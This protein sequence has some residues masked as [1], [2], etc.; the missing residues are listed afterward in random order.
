MQPSYF[1]SR[2]HVLGPLPGQPPPVAPLPTLRA[3]GGRVRTLPVKLG[4]E[5]APCLCPPQ[6]TPAR[7]RVPR[8]SAGGGGGGCFAD[9]VGATPADFLPHSPS[10][11]PHRPLPSTHTP[12]CCRYFRATVRLW[13]LPCLI[14]SRLAL[15]ASFSVFTKDDLS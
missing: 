12:S 4:A 1:G 10:R 8:A 14:T 11:A 5:G 13:L 9:R 7:R 2:A 15:Q 6:R 3:P